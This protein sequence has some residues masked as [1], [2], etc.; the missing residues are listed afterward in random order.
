MTTAWLQLR[1]R[2]EQRRARREEGA[3]NLSDGCCGRVVQEA[4]LRP[5]QVGGAAG[6]PQA[7]GPSTTS[8]RRHHGRAGAGAWAPSD[9]TEAG[10]P[11]SRPRRHA[12]L[13]RVV[14][15]AELISVLRAG[16]TAAADDDAPAAAAAPAPPAPA[17]HVGA[18]RHVAGGAALHAEAAA[19]ARGQGRRR[20]PRPLPA[21]QREDR[22][23]SF[24]LV[25]SLCNSV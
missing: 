3:L 15:A 12:A 2:A 14:P 17:V 20:R 18:L 1:D 6:R 21:L 16:V 22:L 10:A 5:L 11:S 25:A 24:L 19:G 8:R 4:G 7:G 13:V 9:D 23:A